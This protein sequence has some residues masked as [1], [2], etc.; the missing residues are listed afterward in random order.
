MP[1]LSDI[2][3]PKPKGLAARAGYLRKPAMAPTQA[4]QWVDTK[5]AG[6]EAQGFDEEKR[7]KWAEYNKRRYEQHTSQTPKK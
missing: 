5:D 7:K 1:K 3:F 2:L 6:Y 4:E